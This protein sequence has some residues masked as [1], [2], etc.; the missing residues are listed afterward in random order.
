[1]INSTVLIIDDEIKLTQSLAFTLNQA[2]F[3]CLK[4]H[5]G[6]DGCRIAQREKP[7]VVLLDI[8]MPGQNGIEVLQ[9]LIENTPDIPV[10]MMSAF[11]DTQDAV[12]AIK[13]GAIDYLSKP[14]DVDELILLIQEVDKRKQ[15][16]FE[17]RYLRDRFTNDTA[18]IGTS[19]PIKLLREQIDLITNSQVAT[20]LLSGE[21]GVGKA[22]IARQLHI[23]GTSQ[24]SPFVEIN[25]ATLPESQIEAE[26]FGAEKGALPGLVS[27]RRGLVEIA[28][29]GTLFLDEISQM[30]LSVQA[31][32]LTYI[33]T[34]S[35]RP[36]GI[37]REHKS[38][39]RVIAATN[40]SLEQAVEEGT[41]RQDLF[42]RLNVMPVEIPPLRERDTDIQV[43][44]NHFAQKFAEDAAV[45]PIAIGKSALALL[46]GYPWP[47]N[48]RE[49]KNLVERLT[50]LHAGQIIEAD[51]LPS[52]F[53]NVE[54]AGPV[55]I[56]DSMQSVERAMIQDALLKSGGKKG[57][58]AERLGISRHALKRKMQRL[59]LS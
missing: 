3:D 9:W 25:C 7:D 15:L 42:F 35:Y 8:R 31:K 32:L 26:L 46:K 56:E 52:E 19:A 47:G 54:P 44:A 13:M 37:A 2:G 23:K 49:L 51:H 29:G 48:V 21:T 33:E 43:L 22:I 41:F 53:K 40:N 11:D 36:V 28:D 45:R 55:S 4:A 1:M 38:D 18:F 12:T 39:V 57:M 27:R 6:V 30:P 17:V 16:E 34:R 20:V 50:I 24:E 5:N 59:T 14:F 10:I 58:A